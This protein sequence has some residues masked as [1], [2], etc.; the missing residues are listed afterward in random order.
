[1][2]KIFGSSGIRGEIQKTINCQL[3][4]KLGMALATYRKTPLVVVAQDTRPSGTVLKQ[5]LVLG[6]MSLGGSVI[7]VQICPTAGVSFLTKVYNADFGVMV[8]ASHNPYMYNGFKIFDSEG[9]ELCI[10][11]EEE[12]EKFMQQN[13]QISFYGAGK[14]KTIQNASELY[15][16]FLQNLSSVTLDGLKIV[17]DN[18]NGAGQ[19]VSNSVFNNLGA[20]T[21]SISNNP[22]GVFINDGVGALFPELLVSMV[23]Q[24]NADCGFAYDGDADRLIA[25]TKSGRVLNGDDILYILAKN[26]NSC[27]KLKEGKIVT[28]IMTN[29]GIIQSLKAQNIQ[30]II[31]PVGDRFVIEKMQELGLNLGGESSGHIILGD[32]QAVSDGILASVMLAQ[33]IKLTGCSLDSL[34]DA[35]SLSQKEINCNT[36]FAN[37]IINSNELNELTNQISASLGDYGRVVVR[38]SG[39]E[40][41]IRVMVESY[42][43]SLSTLYAE[44]IAKTIFKLDKKLQ[45]G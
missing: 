22:N 8:T 14:C 25:V 2:S 32:Y 43:N 12:L 21:V 18:A 42:S 29:G 5:A 16:E 36:R 44:T 24:Q 11:Q 40:E 20:T 4:T 15:A 26:L 3:A 13:Q 30:S 31:T 37:D 19:V 10:A 6:I 28:T 41:L 27:G 33:I 34:F 45:N 38:K 35:L 23:Q 1:M 39:T 9:E 7:D 17:L